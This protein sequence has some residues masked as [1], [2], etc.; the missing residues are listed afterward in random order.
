MSVGTCNNML[1]QCV[2]KINQAVGLQ[3]CF[4]S[5]SLYAFVCIFSLSVF[6]CHCL[7]TLCLKPAHSF[8]QKVKVLIAQSTDF[9]DSANIV[10][11]Y[12]AHRFL[13]LVFL[14]VFIT[15][16]FYFVAY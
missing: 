13:L 6:Y 2:K 9:T 14:I 12:Y 3:T 15:L 11:G 10:L 8:I 1:V 4:C 7:W 5:M 16:T